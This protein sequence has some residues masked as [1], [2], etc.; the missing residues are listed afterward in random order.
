MKIA[1]S[2]MGR[3]L[4]A[5][6]D[7]RFGRAQ[8]FIIVDSDTLEFEAVENPSISAAG[9]AGI[10][11]GQLMANKGV[12]AILTGNVGPNAFQTLS[13]A[14]IKIITGVTGTVKEAVQRFNS[15]QFQATGS[16]TT[17][18]HAGL[19]GGGT[20][21]GGMGGGMGM[22]RGG[23]MGGGMGRGMGMGGGMGRGMGRGG[24]MGGAAGSWNPMGPGT[25]PMPPQ[26]P[27][28][29][30]PPMPPGQE[31]D[32]LRNMAQSM[33]EQLDQIMKRIKDLENE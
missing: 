9:G 5:E 31:L 17:D 24:G 26:P 4:D 6:V 16:A 29:P 11:S 22:G 25:Q 15:G 33:K 3:D 28:P 13:A 14:N 10:Q 7:P 27:V 18:S 20:F 19:G 21:G 12:E 23:G 1:V 32:N 8:Y 30:A 2:S